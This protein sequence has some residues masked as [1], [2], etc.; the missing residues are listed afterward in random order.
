MSSVVISP[1]PLVESKEIVT[2]VSS[3]PRGAITASPA[4]DCSPSTQYDGKIFQ[5]YAECFSEIE[6]ISNGTSAETWKVRHRGSNRLFVLKKLRLGVRYNRESGVA[7]LDISPAKQEKI[8]REVDILRKLSHDGDGGRCHPGIACY[9]DRFVFREQVGE[10]PAERYGILMEYIDGPTLAQLYTSVLK[11]RETL[12]IDRFLSLVK[13]AYEAL[14]Y[15]H[16]KGVAH[17]DLKPENVMVTDNGTRAVLV[18]FGLA[19]YAQGATTEQNRYVCTHVRGG[20]PAYQAPEILRAAIDGISLE[21]NMALK[22]DVWALACA[23]AELASGN[24]LFEASGTADMYCQVKSKP[25][26][27]AFYESGDA[28]AALVN[29][30][31]ERALDRDWKTRPSAALT[32]ARLESS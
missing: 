30:A 29:D 23:L 21:A 26:P 24:L 2:I 20:T 15:A 8:D 1:V 32:V 10:I 7:E 19:C 13:S 5:N 22:G 14:T 31:L 25:L 12:A 28:R 16:S 4:V 18:D 27:A 17:A 3:D 6:L 9:Y 11:K